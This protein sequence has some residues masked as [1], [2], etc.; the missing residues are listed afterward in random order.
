MATHANIAAT[1][2]SITFSTPKR[3]MR[4]PVKNDGPNIAITCAEMT[5]AAAA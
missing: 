3:W 1:P 2:A 4:E 5:L